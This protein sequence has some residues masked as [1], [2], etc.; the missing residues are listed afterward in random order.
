MFKRGRTCLVSNSYLKQKKKRSSHLQFLHFSLVIRIE[1]V[2]N[3]LCLCFLNRNFTV[4]YF[5]ERKIQNKNNTFKIR[6]FYFGFEVYRFSFFCFFLIIF[7][8]TG[9]CIAINILSHEKY[10]F[11]FVLNAPGD[12]KCL[13]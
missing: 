6:T 1:V 12:G 7:T 11:L 8:R 5:T 4:K 2:S 13:L 9:A 10:R 3:F